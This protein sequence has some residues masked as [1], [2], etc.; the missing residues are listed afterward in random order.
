[1]LVT[2][3]ILKKALVDS[4]IVETED[5]DK[6]ASDAESSEVP[7]EELIIERKLIPDAYLGQLVAEEIDQPF[8]NLDSVDI[9]DHALRIIPERVAKKKKVI[10]FG[11]DGGTGVKLAMRNPLDLEFIRNVEKKV[12]VKAVPYYV[13]ESDISNGFDAYTKDLESAIKSLLAGSPTVKVKK[14]DKEDGAEDGKVVRIVELIMNYAFQNDASDV[15]VE[16]REESI[17]VRYRIDGILHDVASLPRKYQESL[18]TRIKILSKMRTDE[19]FAAQ[20]GKFQETIEGDRIDVRVSIIP[21]VSGEKIVMRLLAE[22]GKSFD[23]AEVGLDGNDLKKLRR[24]AKKSFGMILSTGPTGSGK[25][26]TLYATLR[27][28]NTRD[29]N[30]ATIE[31]PIEYAIDG[32]NQIQVNPKTGL[33]FASGLRSIVRQDPDIIMVGEIRDP[34]TAS[35]AVNAAMTGHLV[36]ST[37]H[38]NDAATALPRFREMGVEPFL[39]ASTINVII[40]QRLVRKICQRC[41][42]SGVI[43]V[44]VLKENFG[45]ELIEKHLAATGMKKKSV[46]TYHGK[47]C[48][49]C[50]HSGFQ[51]RLG[52]FEVL[53]MD[54]DIRDLVMKNANSKEMSQRAIENGM[55][56]M[57]DDGIDKVLQGITTIDEV[58]RVTGA[59]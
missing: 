50:N 8:V 27:E 3:E 10:A 40:A 17:V 24:H 39:I 34:D 2:A 43:G 49:Q 12:G 57:L 4:G 13:T 45:A 48:D 7:L 15:H 46:N 1:M 51:G 28:L 25:T 36:L 29:V 47:G 41:I 6:V 11:L 59:V 22:K 20:D 21:I 30:V 35:I 32:V 58:L 56:T 55:T 5:F 37:L 23:L 54:D 38:T 16:P 53:E 26:T 33:T 52:I 19:H 18:V 44:D 14:K 31:D 42:V 9:P